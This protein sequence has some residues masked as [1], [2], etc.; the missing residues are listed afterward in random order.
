MAAEHE[1]EVGDVV[2]LRDTVTDFDTGAAVTPTPIA[3]KVR[4]PDGVLFTGTP[5]QDGA[6]NEFVYDYLTDQAGVHH[7][8]FDGGGAGA[9]A[10]EKAFY[11]KPSRVV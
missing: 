3:V 1:Y 9:G 10:G 7:Y 4:K 8:R 2:R 11:V 5:Q 6:T